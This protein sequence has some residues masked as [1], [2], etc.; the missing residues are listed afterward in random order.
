MASWCNG[1]GSRRNNF[2]S[3]GFRDRGTYYRY[4]EETVQ[5]DSIMNYNVR[6]DWC[7]TFIPIFRKK[8]KIY[9]ILKRKFLNTTNS[10][11]GNIILSAQKKK[12]IGL[13]SKED[14]INYGV[15]DLQEE[16]RIFMWH[17]KETAP[18]VLK[19]RVG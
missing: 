14:A 8:L 13:L 19:D 9:F 16:L 11:P 15:M 12:G 17:K 18:T 10:W 2:F 5:G 1:H 3:N 7:L 6:A 4:F